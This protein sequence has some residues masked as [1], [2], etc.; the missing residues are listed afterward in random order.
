MKRKVY[1]YETFFTLPYSTYI[2]SCQ[3][4]TDWL[5]VWIEDQSEQSSSYLWETDSNYV[6]A[7]N[8]LPE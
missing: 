1:T 4:K 7:S 8:R 2:R 5:Q 3:Q 6:A